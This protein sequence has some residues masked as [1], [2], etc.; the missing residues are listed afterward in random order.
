MNKVCDINKVENKFGSSRFGKVQRWEIWMYLGIFLL[1]LFLRIY[2]LGEL[3]FG[4]NVDEAGMGYDAYSI[5]HWGMDRYYKFYPLYFINYGGGQSVLYGYLCAFLMKF[6]EPSLI[7]LRMPAV[8]LGMLTWL[9]GTLLIH[10]S[11][12]K[13]ASLAGATLLA[14]CPC[15]ILLSRLGMDCFLFSGTSTVSM[16]FMVQAI[17][18]TGNRKAVFLYLVAG[19]GFGLSLYTYALSWLVMPIFLGSIVLYLFY[20]RRITWKEIVIFAVP[21]GL[22]AIPLIIF[23]VINILKLPEIATVYFTIP[24][25]P[26]FRGAEISLRNIINNIPKLFQIYFFNDDLAYNSVPTYFTMYIV[27]VP[28]ALKGIER[29]GKQMIDSLK[30]KTFSVLTVVL[31]WLI[32]QTYMG[33]IIKEPNVNKLNGAYYALLFFT[34]YGLRE[35][36]MSIKNLCFRRCFTA[37]VSAL[38][39]FFSIAFSVYYFGRYTEDTFPLPLFWETYAGI[40]D[41]WEEKIGEKTVYT[42]APYIYYALGEKLSPMEFQLIEQGIA[43][44][45]NVRFKLSEEQDKDGFYIIFG[46]TGYAERL[47]EAGFTS[48]R[49]GK[50]TVLYWEE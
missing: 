47:E 14:V 27:S 16:Y 4:M 7:L 39:L 38:Y 36:W 35:S 3:P 12:G 37:L 44:R 25:L 32:A 30:N 17:K 5:A 21:V 8:V 6:F 26:A 50:F 15:F 11:M 48:R 1:A 2:K 45:G 9:F 42:D 29:A 23:L 46:R 19:V 41:E 28:F 18:E 22:F 10:E 49:S 33:L 20:I 24:R 34:V 40:M 13:K 31:F 43:E